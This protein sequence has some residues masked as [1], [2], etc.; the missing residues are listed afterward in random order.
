[1]TCLRC[2]GLAVCDDSIAVQSG[3]PANCQ[4]WRCVNCGMITD[5]VIRRNQH[6]LPRPAARTPVHPRRFARLAATG[7]LPRSNGSS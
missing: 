7:E 5:D 4:V 2:H 3:W 6:A 1:M